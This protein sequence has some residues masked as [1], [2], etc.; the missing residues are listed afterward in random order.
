MRI[1]AKMCFF[2]SLKDDIESQSYGSKNRNMLG[3]SY[4]GR[5][6]PTYFKDSFG[7]VGYVALIIYISLSTDKFENQTLGEVPLCGSTIGNFEM[8]LWNFSFHFTISVLLC[9]CF[10]SA[11]LNEIKTWVEII[12]MFGLKSTMIVA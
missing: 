4:F 3:Y 2:L 7:Q 9:I 12:V 8:R 11:L 5:F 6:R 10:C 1:F